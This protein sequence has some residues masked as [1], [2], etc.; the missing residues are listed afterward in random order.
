MEEVDPMTLLY[1]SFIHVCTLNLAHTRT[2][3][4]YMGQKD[5]YNPRLV[6]IINHLLI[7]HVMTMCN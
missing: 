6:H 3:V 4:F 2:A 7:I 1:D 5:T